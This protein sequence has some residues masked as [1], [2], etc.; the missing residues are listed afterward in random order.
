LL[1]AYTFSAA[2]YLFLYC[3]ETTANASPQQRRRRGGYRTQ[4]HLPLRLLPA[5]HRPLSK[6]TFPPPPPQTACNSPRT[7]H[8]RHCMTDT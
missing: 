1:V 8:V 2:I 5:R 7:K 4:L 3:G 6:R